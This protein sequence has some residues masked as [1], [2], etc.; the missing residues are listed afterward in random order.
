MYSKSSV[1]KFENLFL[2]GGHNLIVHS[3]ENNMECSIFSLAHRLSFP[4]FL[5]FNIVARYIQSVRGP[6]E[7]IGLQM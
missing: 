7:T 2:D 5:F 1:E 3:I 6:L 4:I